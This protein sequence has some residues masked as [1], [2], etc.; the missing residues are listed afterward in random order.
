MN[1][2]DGTDILTQGTNRN[3]TLGVGN[4]DNCAF[5]GAYSTLEGLPGGPQTL[6][7]PPLS[8]STCQAGVN[9]QITHSSSDFQS[10]DPCSCTQAG[11]RSGADK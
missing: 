3:A 8:A 7:L 1:K 10:A 11:P 4:G 5:P 2:Q 9:G 6:S